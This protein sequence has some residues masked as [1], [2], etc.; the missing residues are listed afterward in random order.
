MLLSPQVK[1]NHQ[2]GG[3]ELPRFPVRCAVLS[4]SLQLPV[5]SSL[6]CREDGAE[7][8]CKPRLLNEW[9]IPPLTGPSVPPS[10][11]PRPLPPPPPLPGGPLGTE[12]SPRPRS[13]PHSPASPR[14]PSSL[15]GCWPSPRTSANREERTELKSDGRGKR[16]GRR[17]EGR[18]GSRDLGATATGLEGP[19]DAIHRRPSPAS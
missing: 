19:A 9:T 15:K 18:C 14:L 10:H 16:S 5:P 8:P 4:R 12:K 6:T 17:P 3:P 2:A 13:R 11:T 7:E 1:G